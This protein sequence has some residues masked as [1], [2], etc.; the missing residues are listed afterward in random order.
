M[1]DAVQGDRSEMTLGRL[2]QSQG[3]S[4]EVR[5]FGATL[6]ADHTKGHAEATSLAHKIHVPT[7]DK[8]MPEAKAELRKLQHLHGPAFDREAR[9]YMIE[10]HRK[11][12]SEFKSQAR[13]GDPRTAAFAKQTIPVLQKHL[14]QAEALPKY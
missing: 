5:A 2:I 13:H 14:E 8:M 3:H 9:R 11:D 4:A 12:L 7:E 6:V 10:D 1:N